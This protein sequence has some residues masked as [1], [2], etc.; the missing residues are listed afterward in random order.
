MNVMQ[1]RQD[2]LFVLIVCCNL[3]ECCQG[4]ETLALVGL[5]GSIHTHD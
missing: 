1:G 5:L 4:I 3:A 2:Q